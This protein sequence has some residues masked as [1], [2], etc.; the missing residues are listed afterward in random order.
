[1]LVFPANREREGGGARLQRERERKKERKK[2]R[3]RGHA[4]ERRLQRERE[5]ERKNEREGTPMST[6]YRERARLQRER[7]TKLEC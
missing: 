7:P 4:D 5:R 6:A 3:K 1:L 2:E